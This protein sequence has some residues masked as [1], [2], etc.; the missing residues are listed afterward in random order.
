MLLQCNNPK[1]KAPF[2]FRQGRLFRF[3]QAAG[4]A[5][6][7]PPKAHGVRHFWLCAA[8]SQTYTLEYRQDQVTLLARQ[9]VP[10]RWSTCSRWR[11]LRGNR[12]S[13]ENVVAVS[14]VSRRRSDRSARSRSAKRYGSGSAIVPAVA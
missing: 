14:K 13:N 5:E 7:L 10:P 8:C 1:C 9:V 4:K 11:S 12:S 2:D 3:F 6:E